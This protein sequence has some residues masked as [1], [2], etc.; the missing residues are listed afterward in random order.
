MTAPF[1]GGT[2]SEVGVGFGDDV[3]VG[4]PQPAMHADSP[5]AGKISRSTGRR[6]LATL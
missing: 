1:P 5:I 6:I 2:G 4:D 3:G